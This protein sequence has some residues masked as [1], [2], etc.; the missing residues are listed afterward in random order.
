M[1]IRAIDLLG[2]VSTLLACLPLASQQGKTQSTCAVEYENH[3]QI[4]YGPLTIQELKGTVT[5]P[6]KA[7]M[8]KV[9]L[10][11]FTEQGHKLVAVTETDGDGTFSFQSL[12]PGRYR[13]IAKAEPL[14]AANV[15]L[16]VVRRLTRKQVLLVHMEPR[17]LD[18][19]SHGETVQPKSP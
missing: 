1:G 13:L 6:Q 3:N 15:P 11:V 19:C 2:L 7:A 8:P 9:C 12:P 5:D 10:A 4:D 14:C 17:G 18:T 16:R